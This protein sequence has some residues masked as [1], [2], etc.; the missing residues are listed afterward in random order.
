M[1]CWLWSLDRYGNSTA[2]VL[3]LVPAGNGDYHAVALIE[4]EAQPVVRWT[5]NM[6]TVFTYPT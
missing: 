2:A 4:G 6:A 1:L 5:Q 3:C